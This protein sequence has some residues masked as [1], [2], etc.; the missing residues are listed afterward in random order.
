M[1]WTDWSNPDWLG[2]WM[3]QWPSSPAKVPEAIAEN[4]ARMV[5][6]F[7]FS[8]ARLLHDIVGAAATGL[9][10]R[11]IETVVG[12]KAVRFVLDDLRVD[13]PQY[14]PLVGQFGEIAVDVR[15]VRWDG[16][17]VERL[18]INAENLHIRPGVP[19]VIVAAPIK[20]SAMIDQTE[21]AALLAERTER[22]VLRLSDGVATVAPVGRERWAHVEISPTVSGRTINLSPS[23]MVVRNRRFRA[24]V[25]LLPKVGLDLPVVLSDGRLTDVAVEGDRLRLDAVVDEWREILLPAE[26][27]DL[28]RRLRR[29]G[30]EHFRLPRTPDS[31]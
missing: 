30:R 5:D 14:G 2:K 16:R 20:L 1:S 25:R 28:E 31:G 9:A 12:G 11:E 26:L 23:A 17:S 3:P 15:D 27:K 4:M 18:R 21:I 24:P 10:G 29:P 6:V 8:P 7:G 13:P 19:A 22:V